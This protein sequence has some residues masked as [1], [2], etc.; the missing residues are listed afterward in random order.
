MSR[1]SEAV[2]GRRKHRCEEE[3]FL[4]AMADVQP[5][6]NREDGV[7]QRKDEDADPSEAPGRP[8][9]AT[10]PPPT[11][12]AIDTGSKRI[13]WLSTGESRGLDRRTMDRLRKGQFRPE[14]RL[15]LH[16][17]TADEAVRAVTRFLEN[18][19]AS[20]RRCVLVVTGKGSLRDGGGVLRREFPNWLNL[21]ANRKRVLGFTMA[22]PKD[23][24]GGAFYVLLRR[25]RAGNTG[26]QKKTGTAIKG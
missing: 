8:D 26:L 18:A 11:R 24:G 3:L 17:R 23:G 25:Q 10:T 9:A 6:T 22:R 15:D 14:I 1:Y 7:R 2:R 16:G 4:S 19:Q 12:R 21:P 20:S 13:E 5:I